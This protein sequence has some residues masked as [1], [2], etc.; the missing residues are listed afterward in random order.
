M[1]S[2]MGEKRRTSWKAVADSIRGVLR[3]D[4]AS[5]EVRRGS[6]GSTMSAMPTSPR[7]FEFGKDP[8]R[9]AWAEPVD[10]PPPGAVKLWAA[11][12]DGRVDDARAALQ[13]GA[14]VGWEMPDWD[15][16]ALKYKTRPVTCQA[17]HAAAGMPRHMANAG[18]KARE[19][20]LLLLSWRADVAAKASIS[21]GDGHSRELEA[22]HIAAG[23]G[24]T[25]A[26]QTLLEQGGQ[27]DAEAT[28]DGKLH[29][30][31]IHDAAWF[32]RWKNV[33]CLLKHRA[34]NDAMNKR[35]DTALHIA[36]ALGNV[37]V[38]EALLSMSSEEDGDFA[39][40]SMTPAVAA[41]QLLSGGSPSMPALRRKSSG[42]LAEIPRAED[43]ERVKLLSLQNRDG[44]SPLDLAVEKGQFPARSLSLFTASLDKEARAQAFVKV[45]LACPDAALAL[46]R[47]AP[48]GGGDD[49]AAASTGISEEWR[50]SL[51]LG[52]QNGAITVDVLATLIDHAPPAAADL[53]DVLAETPETVSREHNPLPVRARLPDAQQVCRLSAVYEDHLQWHW[54]PVVF[55]D[56]WQRELAPTDPKMGHE[57]RVRVMHLG[58]IINCE[59]VHC[60]AASRDDHIFT[61]LVV[62]GLLKYMWSRFMWLFLVD[63][64][65]QAAATAVM[66]YWIWGQP[67]G[68]TDMGQLFMWCLVASLGLNEC[69]NFFWGCL[70]C[71]ARLGR[72]KTILWSAR[73][74]HRAVIGGITVALALGTQEELQPG[75]DGSSSIVLSLCGL[76]HWFL[77]LFE[78]RAF[79]WTG[80]RLLPIMKSMQPILAMVVI[81][82]FIGLGFAHAFW[83]LATYPVTM[84]S[85]F[86]IAV[87]LFTGAPGTVNEQTLEEMP[88]DASR[89]VTIF[90]F[91]MSLF[92]FFACTLNLFIAVLA[93][94][95]DQEQ[96]KMLRNFLRERA[97]ICS[98]FFL[99]PALQLCCV[100]RL[101]ARQC[102]GLVL[103]LLLMALTLGYVGVLV[104]SLKA[105]AS[106]WVPALVLLGLIQ[107]VHSVTNGSLTEGWDRRHLWICHEADLRED[108]FLVAEGGRRSVEQQGRIAAVKH[109][110]LDQC[111]ALGAKCDALDQALTAT[112]VELLG[113]VAEQGRKLD[114]L[115]SGASAA[116]AL[117][118]APALGNLN[119]RGVQAAVSS[120]RSFCRL[121]SSESVV[122]QSVGLGALYTRVATVG[123]EVVREDPAPATGQEPSDTLRK[124]LRELEE[125]AGELRAL[126]EQQHA[127]QL[128]LESLCAAAARALRDAAEGQQQAFPDQPQDY[129]VDQ[130]LGGVA[131]RLHLA[132]ARGG[133]ALSK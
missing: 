89:D 24:H 53:L 49:G 10:P 87:L 82:I 35:G 52:V 8:P 133:Q 104:A 131:P 113:V 108:M 84:V 20:I 7:H 14:P 77:L 88:D 23:A 42:A 1:A 46:L 66:S 103:A 112:R 110:V 27:P 34:A 22:I 62:H 21:V 92:V 80:K 5:P 67:G 83:A 63:L 6:F 120:N 102:G 55:D 79:Q 36:A 29:Y 65:H 107:L 70:V 50:Q 76:L 17:L 18:E 71:W 127:A 114:R 95:Y 100:Q 86:S 109:Y 45:A 48:S 37:E 123:P 91:V 115:L 122:T 124:R 39:M 43:E 64:L 12:R 94:C 106:C 126:Q 31:P 97:R 81:M 96:E 58:G 25:L 3:I 98:S 54:S 51:L 56:S 125:A 121:A 128:R 47:S 85:I 9:P 15:E 40:G 57:V 16:R 101:A 68:Y 130:L 116:S 118:V 30:M 117:P 129:A 4:D 32:N 72:G 105:E 78:L 41:S 74:W 28:I 44:K 2:H 99:R 90:M 60:L 19:V 119:P 26:L 111:R 13:E 38:V 33:R 75:G 11:A 61:K 69:I 132:G 59:V 73:V 93:D